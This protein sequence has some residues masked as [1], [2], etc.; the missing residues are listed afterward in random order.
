MVLGDKCD[1]QGKGLPFFLPRRKWPG[2]SSLGKPQTRVATGNLEAM[3]MSVRVK[4]MPW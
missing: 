4:G 2:L 1:T 3:E